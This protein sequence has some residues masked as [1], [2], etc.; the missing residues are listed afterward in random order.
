MVFVWNSFL[1]Q[2]TRHGI[3]GTMFVTGGT[4][5]VTRRSSGT[6]SGSARLGRKHCGLIEW[7]EV[8]L[9]QPEPHASMTF[10]PSPP[11]P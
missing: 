2:G 9:S 10:A 4:G 8:M 3:R 6:R 11:L 5:D 7:A 1:Y